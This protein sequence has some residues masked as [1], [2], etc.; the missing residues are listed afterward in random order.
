VWVLYFQTLQLYPPSTVLSLRYVIYLV[1]YVLCSLLSISSS[2]T[3]QDAGNFPVPFCSTA[4]PTM[5]MQ[6]SQH[7]CKTWRTVT[8]SRPAA[9]DDTTTSQTV[10]L[11]RVRWCC[12]CG[13]HIIYRVAQKKEATKF[14]PYLCQTLADFQHFFTAAFCEKFVVKWLLN[15]PPHLR[16]Y[17]SHYLVKY[18]ICKIHHY[19]VNIWT[20]WSLIFWPILNVKLCFALDR[21]PV[22]VNIIFHRMSQ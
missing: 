14:F 1:L 20:V 10:V 15:I 18:K 16:C 19:L 8:P 11:H 17:T 21:L 13:K 9:L 4:V 2:F 7:Y 6:T 5:K 22:F 3:A 12:S